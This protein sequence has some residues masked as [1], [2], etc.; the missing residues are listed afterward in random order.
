M[1]RGPGGA[2]PER[3]AEVLRPE[4]GVCLWFKW[5]GS[6]HQE[7]GKTE[8]VPRPGRCPDGFGGGFGFC[9]SE[10]PA[11]LQAEGGLCSVSCF[12]ESV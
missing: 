9:P 8:G 5:G 12:C 6:C 4:E 7:R 2:L 11:R 10:A 3:D 1:T